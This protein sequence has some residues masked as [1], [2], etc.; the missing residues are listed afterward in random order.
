[1]YISLYCQHIFQNLTNSADDEDAGSINYRYVWDSNLCKEY[2][3]RIEAPDTVNIFD[4]ARALI[5]SE[6]VTVADIDT[7]LGSIVNGIENC[8]LPLF[9]KPCGPAK[10]IAAGFTENN[11]PWFDENCIKRS[12]FYRFL[13]IFRDDRNEINRIYMVSACSPLRNRYV[14]PD[15]LTHVYR[16]K[17][18][19]TF[20]LKTPKH[21]GNY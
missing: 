14:K 5:S 12:E 19:V 2:K 9:S 21:I 11:L 1:M 6:N 10:E 13:N 18:Y 16:R 3:R 8:T 7:G 17:N 20:A 15:T 4:R